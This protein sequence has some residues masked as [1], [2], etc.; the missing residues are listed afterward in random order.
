MFTF[1]KKKGK[2]FL[3]TIYLIGI[4]YIIKKFNSN[5]IIDIKK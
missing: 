2:L 1:K 4:N 3:I 5:F